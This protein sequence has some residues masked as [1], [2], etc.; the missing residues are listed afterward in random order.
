MRTA[1]ALLAALAG[2]GCSSQAP[3]VGP[4]GACQLA[5]DCQA[6]LICAPARGGGSTCTSNLSGVVQ[7]PPTPDGGMAEGGAAQAAGDAAPSDDVSVPTS[8]PDGSGGGD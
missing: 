7:L 1:L 3:L 2:A 4:G 8:V 6:G 5:T